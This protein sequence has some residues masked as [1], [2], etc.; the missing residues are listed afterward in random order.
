MVYARILEL[1][2]LMQLKIMQRNQLLYRI[3][4]SL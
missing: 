4:L 1:L 3:V 2:L